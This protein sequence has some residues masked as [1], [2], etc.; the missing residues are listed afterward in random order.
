[1]YMVDAIDEYAYCSVRGQEA[2]LYHQGSFETW[3]RPKMRVVM[4]NST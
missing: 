2:S 4:N 3:S 1:M